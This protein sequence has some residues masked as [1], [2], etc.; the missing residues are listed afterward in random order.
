MHNI[1]FSTSWYIFKSKF[2]KEIYIK[3]IDNML[4][5][6]NNYNLVIYSDESSSQYL[7][8]YLENPNIKLIIKPY[9]EFY[10]YR[11]KDFWITNHEQNNLLNKHI[12]W[13][14][15]M[16]WCEKIHFVYET[17]QQKYFDSDFYGWCD[18]GYFRETEHDLSRSDL[19]N[20][21]NPDKLLQL[22]INKIYYACVNNDNKYLNYLYYIISNKNDI[23]LPTTQIPPDQKSCAGGFFISH[24]NNIEWWH[25]TFDSKLQLYFQHNYLVKDDQMIIVDC[26]MSNADYF[27]LFKEINTKY[28]NWFL[29][30][31][32]LL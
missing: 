19:I 31:R 27:C 4:S 5:N 12:D 22:D 10:M 11:Y 25:N 8:K 18:I 2:D 7:Q 21:P 14:V 26:I 29:F 24:K 15:N 13:K 3:W 16:L 23:G 17:M 28:D 9:E 1:T 32:G 30:Q 6:V 20:W